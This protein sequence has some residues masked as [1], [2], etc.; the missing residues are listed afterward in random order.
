MKSEGSA[1]W[2]EP[3][4]G[5]LS[6]WDSLSLAVR[7]SPGFGLV[8]RRFLSV[9]PMMLW[10]ACPLP[11]L[12][13]AATI[14]CAIAACRRDRGRLQFVIK[15]FLATILQVIL[16]VGWHLVITSVMC[17]KGSLRVC[18]AVCLLPTTAFWLRTA[19]PAL[20]AASSP[21][22]RKLVTMVPHI[23]FFPRRCRAVVA[24]FVA[25]I[26]SSVMERA[27]ITHIVT[28]IFASVVERTDV[29]VQR[30]HDATTTGGGRVCVHLFV[31][32]T[33]SGE[34]AP[35]ATSSGEYAPHEWLM[36]MD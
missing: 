10:A 20:G 12:A 4:P 32:A 14:D 30:K 26:V 21:L 11:F 31:D 19:R 1:P 24:H 27:C 7:D 3:L 29:P 17:V 35:D 8:M 15:S 36:E 2:Y 16:P 34:Y 23:T 28:D 25:D 33:S 6:M 9:I 22:I 13:G 18:L 5:Q